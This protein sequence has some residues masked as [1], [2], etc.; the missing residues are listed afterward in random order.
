MKKLIGWGIAILVAI[1]LLRGRL[2]SER[3]ATVYA[4]VENQS[5]YK[6]GSAYVNEDGSYFSYTTKRGKVRG[7]SVEWK[8]GKPI[9]V[10]I[11][12]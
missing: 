12:L 11:P 5:D 1:F 7:F 8:D 6:M 4:I 9:V 10:E 2:Q 3:R